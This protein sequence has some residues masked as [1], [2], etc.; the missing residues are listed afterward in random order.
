MCCLLTQCIIHLLWL[1][2]PDSSGYNCNEEYSCEYTN[3]TELSLSNSNATYWD[4]TI[5]CRGQDSCSHMYSHEHIHFINC[6]G[7]YSCYQSDERVYP[8]ISSY[9]FIYRECQGLYSCSYMRIW[10]DTEN[11]NYQNPFFYGYSIDCSGEL[12]CSDSYIKLQTINS[13]EINGTITSHLYCSGDASCTWSTFNLI[14]NNSVF[15]T[16]N[17]AGQYSTFIG[18]NSSEYLGGEDFDTTQRFYFLGAES[19]ENTTILCGVDEVCYVYCYSNGCDGLR[20][21]C[22]DGDDDSCEFEGDCFEI[23]DDSY[24]CHNSIDYANDEGIRSI[25]SFIYT[26]PSLVGTEMSSSFAYSNYLEAQ[27][28][29]ATSSSNISIKVLCSD[30]EEC[31]EY[32]QLSVGPI[33]CSASMGCL[34]VDNITTYNNDDI[35]SDVGVRCDGYASC[36][37][38]TYIVGHGDD[39]QRPIVSAHVFLAGES[40][41]HGYFNYYD[42]LAPTRIA[43]TLDEYAIGRNYKYGIY[44]TGKYSCSNVYE[45]T[46]AKDLYCVGSSSCDGVDFIQNIDNVYMY[47]YQAAMWSSIGNITS[48][49]YCGAFQSCYGTYI[50]GVD[51]TVY[52]KG[53]QALAY[54]S[55]YE[56]DAVVAYGTYCAQGASIYHVQTVTLPIYS[57]CMTTPFLFSVEKRPSNGHFVVF[58]FCAFFV[59]CG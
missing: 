12:S 27:E 39:S 46:N 50:A 38:V 58:F 1:S 32:D 40:A 23:G 35:G 14:G 6:E 51:E 31:S 20:V 44:C 55:L 37:N 45:I 49:V 26:F 43:T 41:A 2:L 29:E 24:K 17:L 36:I 59:M 19:G 21:G 53:Y 54:A 13:V 48:S 47:A 8:E 18:R 57:V 22:A 16:G 34:G 42:G 28:E 10:M 5:Y 4:D 7:A 9:V 30:F 25:S 11:V 15:L 56:V 3:A 52:G 33:I